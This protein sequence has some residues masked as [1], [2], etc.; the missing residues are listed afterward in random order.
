MKN[1]SP[2]SLEFHA[3]IKPAIKLGF[4]RPLKSRQEQSMTLFRA[5]FRALEKSNIHETLPPGARIG[6]SG[7]FSGFKTGPC[8][9]SNRLIQRYRDGCVFLPDLCPCHGFQILH[10]CEGEPGVPR[11]G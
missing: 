10:R 9:N 4:R 1:T 2:F 8:S 7:I 6:F 3:Q 11:F 5:F